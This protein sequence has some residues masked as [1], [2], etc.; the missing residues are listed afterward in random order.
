MAPELERTRPRHY[1]LFVVE[2]LFLLTRIAAGNTGVL[3]EL[4]NALGA[5][6][7]F[8]RTVPAGAIEAESDNDLRHGIRLS[9]F[10]RMLAHWAPAGGQTGDEP[11]GSG[12]EGGWNQPSRLAWAMI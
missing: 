5:I 7:E 10:E 6:L 9:W 1:V 8:A 12:W 4:T 11:D 2:P 3:P